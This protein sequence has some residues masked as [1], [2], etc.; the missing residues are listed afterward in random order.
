MKRSFLTFCTTLLLL[1]MAMPSVTWA[2]T[3]TDKAINQ[4]G[5]IIGTCYTIDES[6]VAGGFSGTYS[7]GS[8]GSAGGVKL[9]TNTDGDRIVFNI[10]APYTIT[11]FT[12]E[13]YSNN[14]DAII[15]ATKVE[16]VISA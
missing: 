10:T 15:R 1:A 4:T 7:Y 16:D 3:G 8:M 14:T 6:F 2:S 11:K 9:R 5:T 12:L 13:A